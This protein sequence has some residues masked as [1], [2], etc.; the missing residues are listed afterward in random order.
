MEGEGTR[1]E[2]K[3]REVMGR[4][5]KRKGWCEREEGGERMTEERG[6]IGGRRG[7]ERGGG[8]GT[9]RGE[10]GREGKGTAGGREGRVKSGE[11][12]GRWSG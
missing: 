6:G 3:R 5:R 2:G 1:K 7:R 11:M 10:G 4:E 12:G 8:R 9:R